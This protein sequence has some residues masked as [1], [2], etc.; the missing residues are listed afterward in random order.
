MTSRVQPPTLPC[1]C[2][3]L[4]RATRRV[5]QLYD[6]ALRPTGLR[7]TQFTLLQALQLAG[8]VSQNDLGELL[9][10]D[11]TT[12]SRSLAPLAKRGWIGARAGADRRHRLWSLTESGEDKLRSST[13]AWDQAQARLERQLGPQLWSD[14]FR[15]SHQ[16][17]ITSSS[18]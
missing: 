6:E 5:T 2:A 18:K 1:A 4:R 15:V 8:E 3:N 13:T 7:S 11:S 16:A 9:A 17:L 14:L 12:L 10:I